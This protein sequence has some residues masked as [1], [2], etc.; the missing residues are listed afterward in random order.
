MLTRYLVTGGGGF[1]GSHLVEDLARAGHDVAV[2]DDFSTGRPENLA[3]VPAT[4]EAVDG[5]VRD[6]DAVADAASGADGIFHLAALNSMVRSFEDPAATLATNLGG[7]VA[8]V[9]A[10]RR[11]GVRRVVLASS[12]SVYGGAARV[13]RRESDAVAPLSPYAESKVEAERVCL[14]A[15]ADR[16]PE[17]VCLRYFNVYGPHQDPSSPYAAAI[18]RFVSSFLR[19]EPPEI[20]GDGEQTRDFTFVADVVAATAAAMAVPEAAGRVVNIGAGR[21][22]S[23]NGL[24][25]LIRDL[26]ESRAG[27]RHA[28]PRRGEVRHAVADVSLAERVLGYRPQWMLAEGLRPTIPWYRER[29]EV[30]P[31]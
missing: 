23:V 29:L 16:G 7:T 2:L 5:D 28:P 10:A 18:P 26:V 17:A 4:V 25:Q 15:A 27:V 19:D 6:A 22:T 9:D 20:Y 12:S 24:V 11:R 3:A 21:S 1:I 14:G 13:L 30:R 31:A 8:V